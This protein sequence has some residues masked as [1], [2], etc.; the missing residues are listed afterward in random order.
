MKD[1]LLEILS[2]LGLQ[3][4][5]QVLVKNDIDESLLFDLNETELREMNFSLGQ[6]KKFVK[7]LQSAAGRKV[8]RKNFPAGR[9]PAERRQLTVAFCDLVGSTNLATA[10]DAEDVRELMSTYQNKVLEIMRNHGG[11]LAYLQ[12]D[13]LMIY[14]GYP[15]AQEDDAARAIRASLAI[16]EAVAELATPAAE[17][18]AVRIGLATGIV[19]VGE[20]IGGYSDQSDFVIGETP[21]LA[22][23][24]QGLAQPGEIVIA[25]ETRELAG[26]LFDYE[27]MGDQALKGFSEL[28][29]TFRVLGESQIQSRFQARISDDLGP[30]VGREEELETLLGLWRDAQA[31]KGHICHVEGQPGIGK[32][33]LV[34]GLTEHLAGKPHEAI[35]LQC[36]SHLSNRALHPVTRELERAAGFLKTDS[37]A[38]RAGK[39][40]AFIED[41]AGY[42]AEDFPILADLLGIS[43]DDQLQIDAQTRA[44]ITTEMLR[45]RTAAQAA[46]KPLFLILEDAHWSD[47]MT[48]DFIINMSDWVGSLPVLVLVTFR[49]EFEPPWTGHSGH[50]R[51]EPLNETAGERLIRQV[52]GMRDL[53][54]VVAREI[55]QK[56]DGVP[57]FV[58][59]LTKVVLEATEGDPNTIDISRL[60]AL[61][62]PA[63]L[64]DSLM[65]RLDRTG[66]GREVAQLGS[67]IGR[68]FTAA[69]IQ[70]IGPDDLDIDLGLEE[71]LNA[72]LIYSTETSGQRVFVFNHALVQDVAYDSILK[73]RRR[74]IHADLAGAM[75][76]GHTAFGT[77]EPEVLARH[78]DVAGMLNEAVENW[79]AAGHHALGQANNLAAVTYLKSALD[80]LE[81]LPETDER[82]QSELAV[83]MAFAP[84]CMATYGWG[85][86]EVEQACARAQVLAQKLGDGSSLFGSTWGLWTNYF[87]RGEMVPAMSTALET[88]A[89]A[90]AAGV[91]MLKTAADHAVGYT[92]FYR[93]EISEALSRADRGIARY[94]AEDEIGIIQT[95][96]FSSTVALRVFRAPC[97]WLQGQEDAASSAFD[98]A[99]A[100]SK[101]VDH[102]P[103]YAYGLGSAGQTLVLQRDWERLEAVAEECMN[104]SRQHG[105]LLWERVAAVQLALAHGHLGKSSDPISEI[106][107]ERAKFF[108]T[109]TVLTDVLI[110]PAYAELI[111]KLGDPEQARDRLGTII[112]ESERRK[113]ELNLPELYRVRGEALRHLGQTENA[114]K[115]F[116]KAA[117]VA[118]NQGALHL[119]KFAQYSKEILDAENPALKTV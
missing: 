91:P 71:L 42:T 81:K 95:F 36:G 100:F 57:L 47:P 15:V 4:F 25:R 46:E 111:I 63:T 44:N 84:A 92:R 66:A 1:S 80:L 107:T 104:I 22:S 64:H 106:D 26:G 17:P 74:E 33:R 45:R 98:E 70:A 23:R 68:E 73:S 72:G 67:V 112:M 50:I 119:E 35:L 41:A 117:L 87:L 79:L 108:A 8:K 18:L 2:E 14:F 77:P 37:T 93:G 38:D 51:L 16:S 97:L 116:D 78:C 9:A 49:P 10:L 115:D 76:G 85:S 99:L 82:A 30:L 58:E 31:G 13:G 105:F 101:E 54:P 65:A 43:P 5:H 69:M 28:V 62:I 110:F 88:D 12:G 7:A 32:S 20:M 34:S 94:S 86:D 114:R 3:E 83:Q 118:R 55:I 40:H 109:Q 102:L 19:V 27:S 75:L 61:S 29:E 113:E 89:M 59:E 21:N 52:A 39:L 103:S 6:R 90:E 24:L 48:Q 60:N 53:P 96:Q 56:T 11:H